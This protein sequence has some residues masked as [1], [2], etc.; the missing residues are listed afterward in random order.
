MVALAAFTPWHRPSLAEMADA[1][2]AR[3]LDDWDGEIGVGAEEAGVLVA[4]AWVRVV[5]PVLIRDHHGEPLPEFIIAVDEPALGLYRACGPQSAA[6]QG[7]PSRSAT[8]TSPFRERGVGRRL[9]QELQQ[10]AFADRG[11]TTSGQLAM[12]WAPSPRAS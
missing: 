7:S 12:A 6:C 4:A 2:V 9:L 5:Q 1:R 8:K 11:H 10:L 3:W